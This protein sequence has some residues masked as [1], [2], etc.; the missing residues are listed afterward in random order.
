MSAAAENARYGA[1]AFEG[2]T[3]KLPDV[4]PREMGSNCAKYVL[5]VINAGLRSTM[6]T[7]FEEAFAKEMSV[8]HCIGTPGC[9]PALSVLTAHP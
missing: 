7:R 1:R 6:T 9:T 4:F 3:E 8:K 2:A 5:E